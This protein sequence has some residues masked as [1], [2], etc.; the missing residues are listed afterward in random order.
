[1]E[2]KLFP[3]PRFWTLRG[4]RA[5]FFLYRPQK[6]EKLGDLEYNVALDSKFFCI[7]PA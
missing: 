2:K 1:M 6:G 5:T 3:R 7:D 4:H